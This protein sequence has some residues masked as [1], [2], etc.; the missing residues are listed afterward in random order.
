MDGIWERERSQ[1]G[2]T[3][4]WD[5]C[6]IGWRLAPLLRQGSQEKE[7]VGCSGQLGYTD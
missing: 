1:D 2:P 5:L 3:A 7:W 6:L 4:A